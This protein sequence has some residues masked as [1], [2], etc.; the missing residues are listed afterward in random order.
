MR[1]FK[2]KTFLFLDKDSYGRRQLRMSF[3]GAPKRRVGKNRIIDAGFSSP[4]STLHFK[5]IP[6]TQ[7][8]LSSPYHQ[9]TLFLIIHH[10]QK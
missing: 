10:T 8:Y 7:G 4:L 3:D 9:E 6:P 2:D 5:T 1:F